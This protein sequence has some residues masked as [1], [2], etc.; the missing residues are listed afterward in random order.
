MEQE[1][2]IKVVCKRCGYIW[3]TKTK[4]RRASCPKCGFGVVVEENAK[5]IKE[6]LKQTSDAR[7]KE[8][9]PNLKNK[10]LEALEVV[11]NGCSYKWH[12][13]SLKYFVTCP[14]CCSKVKIEEP[15]KKK[16]PWES[17]D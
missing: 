12:T 16:Q 3:S 9:H 14:C 2:Q 1:T 6:I 4:R 7:F 15:N 10:R 11:C 8:N 5:V 13:R 17:E